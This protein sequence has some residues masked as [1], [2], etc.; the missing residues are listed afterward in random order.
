MKK[1]FMFLILYFIVNVSLFSQNAP[2][3]APVNPAFTRYMEERQSGKASIPLTDEFGT[4]AM[5][6]PSLVNFDNYLK[7]NNLKSTN[8]DLVYDMRTLKPSMLTPVR[9]QTINGCWAFATIA[10]VESQWLVKG[11]GSWDL[12]ENNLKFCHGFIASRSYNG[13]HWMSTAYFAR[14]SGPLAELDDPNIDGSTSPAEC[15]TGK[16]PVSYITDA[17]FLPNDIPTVKKAILDHGAIFT[18]M[19]I[20]QQAKYY[21]PSDFTYYYGDSANVNH[22]VDLVGWDDTKITTGGIGAWICRNSYGTKWGDS[23]YFYV[24]FNDRYILD[25]PA[26]WPSRIENVPSSQVY[27]YDDLGY[28]RSFGYTSVSYMLVKFSAGGKQL[29]SKLGTYAV[30]AGAMIEFDIFDTFDPVTKKLSDSLCRLGNLSCNLPG[31]YTFDLITPLQVEKGNDFYVRVRY[32]T[33]DYSFPIPIETYDLGFSSP[34]IESEKA[35]VSGTGANS[36]WF[37]IGETTTD[38]KWDPCVKV[39]A[40]PYPSSLT[41]NGKI[42]NDWN[43]A[44]N[45]SPAILPNAAVDVVIPANGTRNPVVNQPMAAPAVCKNL[46]INAGSSVT[47]KTDKALTV[48]GTLTN[49]AG[50]SGLV[51][52]TGASLITMG[53]V[54]GTATVKRDISGSKWHFIS[55]PVSDALSGIFTG[56]YLQKHTENTNAYSY[57][58]SV[59]EPLVPV[60]GYALWGTTDFTASYT[61]LLNTGLNS[62]TLTRTPSTDP[63]NRGWNL[64][65]NPYPSSIDWD[66]VSG[67]SKS[68]VNNSIYIESNGGWATY[69]SGVGGHSGLA[70]NDGSRYIAP[71]QG[72]FVSVAS[73]K[74]SGTLAM[75]DGVRVHKTI[76]F[77]KN[78][79]AGSLVKLRVSGNGFSDEAIVRFL[80]EAT[81]EYD[82]KYDAVKLF[83]TNTESA[84]IYTSGSNSL[85]INTLPPDVNKV[86][87]GIQAKKTGKYAISAT[88]I[89][90]LDKVILEDTKTGDVTRLSDKRYLFFFEAGEKELRFNLYFNGSMG[91]GPE[92]TES[93][94]ASVYSYNQTVYV[95]MYDE[96][97]GDI[98]IYNMEGKMA[99][100][101]FSARGINSISL[102][103]TGIFIVKVSTEQSTM[104]KRVL[105]Q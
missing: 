75:D 76:A 40:E 24:S 73:D 78:S 67:W 12:S 35:W 27:G 38:Y 83:G 72:F 15:P 21:N 22:A 50:N 39:Y 68:H 80:P 58:T 81:A 104:V 31:Y 60:Q 1:A 71:G 89:N 66:A 93:P 34:F 16:I 85:T 36:S 29:L 33:P 95:N 88:E 91:T 61:G 28:I 90:N 7:T 52:E 17:R 49:S 105:I 87:L 5:P 14:R 64:V 82:P 13:N 9:G 46:T 97:K 25:Y 26:Y 96:V 10:S 56:K 42:S 101:R 3:L 11:L 23:G 44:A 65:G 59:S 74:T 69:I 18:M 51:L 41:W 37:Q 4:G 100:S 47:V 102:P 6:P 84:Q 45:W 32:E 2:T 20:D 98:F 54:T 70:T 43:T 53:N 55:P 8:F 57:I 30:A 19:C 103:G 62:I 86:A 77:L 94:F 63:D 48:N 99:A 92:A 79:S